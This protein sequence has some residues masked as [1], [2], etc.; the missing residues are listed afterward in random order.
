MG[1]SIYKNSKSIFRDVGQRE[2]SGILINLGCYKRLT[3]LKSIMNVKSIR[4][5]L[6]LLSEYSSI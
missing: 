1:I 3:E 4:D 2:N 6:N 5:K